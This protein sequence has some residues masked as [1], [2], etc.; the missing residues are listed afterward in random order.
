MRIA[1]DLDGTLADSASDITA[2]LE[3][4]QHDLVLERCRQSESPLAAMILA[5][6]ASGRDAESADA[7]R[8]MTLYGGTLIDVTYVSE[9]D[10]S[11]A[12]G[13]SETLVKVRFTASSAKAVLAW[14][15]HIACRWDW[16][17]NAD[18][19]PRAPVLGD[20]IANA[21]RIRQIVFNFDGAV[22]G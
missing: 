10:V 18:G 15:G 9:A 8:V 14:G 16:G 1:F 5:E 13:S 19:S 21:Q 4:K 6:A 11:L 7:E 12:T 17:F 2:A 20:G 22:V 3:K